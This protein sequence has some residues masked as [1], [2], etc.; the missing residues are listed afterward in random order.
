MIISLLSETLKVSQ[1]VN[2]KSLTYLC[3]L[4]FDVNIKFLSNATLEGDY[5]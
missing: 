2:R 4:Q 5:I 1:K 3:I